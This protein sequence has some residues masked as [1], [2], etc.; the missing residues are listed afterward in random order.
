MLS[1]YQDP[2]WVKRGDSTCLLPETMY[3]V[4][5]GWL[6]NDMHPELSLPRNKT[7]VMFTAD[8]CVACGSAAPGARPR[9]YWWRYI[10]VIGLEHRL[11]ELFLRCGST[12]R[13]AR[14]R[15]AGLVRSLL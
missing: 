15:D 13:I 2:A 9:R 12:V 1:R 11:R 6:D 8:V 10:D 4:H 14:I 5:P 7:G 3:I